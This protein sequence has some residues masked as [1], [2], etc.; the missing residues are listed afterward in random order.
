MN[1]KPVKLEIN[2]DKNVP[3]VNHTHPFDVP[4]HLRSVWEKEIRDAIEGRGVLKPVDYA[5][6]WSSKAFTVAKNDSSKV[7]I[8][9]DFRQLNKALKHPHW[10]TESS[11]QLLRHVCP[12]SKYYVTVDANS[13]NHQVP[14]AKSSQPYLSIVT[15]QGK[16][17]YTVTPQ[18]V[19]SIS[20]LFY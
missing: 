16:F 12:K 19:S 1:I 17:A 9:A 14:V 5:T 10:P 11:C 6:E 3:P 2:H 8:V 18:G 4:Y 15:Q 13:G 20:D 7:R